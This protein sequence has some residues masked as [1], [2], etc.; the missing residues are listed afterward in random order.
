LVWP[1]AAKLRPQKQKPLKL[2]H[3]HQRQQ[4]RHLLLPLLQ[5]TLLPRHPLPPLLR[6][7]MLQSQLR[8]RKS[9]SFNVAVENA[10]LVTGVFFRLFTA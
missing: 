3:Q 6:L 9:K 4:H 2:P 10:G 8:H 7:L 1:L 5:L